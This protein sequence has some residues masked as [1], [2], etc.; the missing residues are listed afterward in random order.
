MKDSKKIKK[1]IKKSIDKVLSHEEV[2][3]KDKNPKPKTFADS[4]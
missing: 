3:F 2:V 1:E 4:K